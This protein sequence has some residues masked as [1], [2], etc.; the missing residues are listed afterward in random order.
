LEN[1]I[2]TGQ[3][4]VLIGNSSTNHIQSLGGDDL[5]LGNDS[6]DKLDGGEGIDTVSYQRDLGSIDVNLGQ[7]KAK[8][9]FGRND[10][11]LNL[12]NVIGSTFGDR[13]IGNVQA[14]LITAGKG[15]DFVSGESGNDKLFGN[16]GNFD[17]LFG[18]AGNDTITDDDG[19]F[20]AHGGEDN[21]TIDVAFVSDW[22]SPNGQRR[23]DGKITGGYGNDNITV[24][25]NH[26]DF[27]INLKGDEPTSNTPND[28]NDIA[29]LKGTYANSV[30][31]LG[32]GKDTFNGGAGNDNIAAGNGDD[33]LLG[34]SG[35]DK[36]DGQTG[37][38]DQI[39]GGKG[40]DTILDRDGVNGAHGNEGNDKIEIEFAS[41]WDNNDNPNDNPRSDGKITGGF[42]N[43]QITVAMNDNR[44]F[45]N[46]KGDEPTSNQ[47]QDGNDTIT[48]IGSYANSVVDLGGGNDTFNGGSGSD[49]VSG[50]NGNDAIFGF[51]GND[52]LAGD[53]GDDLLRG[54][55][56]KDKLIGGNGS[57][58]FVLAKGEGID[59]IVDFQVELDLIGLA[60][61]LTYGQLSIIQS[62][63]NSLVRNGNETLAILN[64]ITASDLTQGMFVSI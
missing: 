37:F 40:N 26:R 53:N 19:I 62:D 28:G 7:N 34:N 18:G 13:I 23:S 43:D 20:G 44:F 55:T 50:K 29:T 11:L 59:T 45:I 54:G 64:G 21:D 17:K 42:G 38:F 31:D 9:G 32:G 52:Q 3:N 10:E 22:N 41:N 12:E 27:F 56:G 6:D 57:D 4:D 39:F 25:M 46:L 2:A 24:T 36:L 8:E 16:E 60:D 61:G 5:L 1:I 33:R 35:N 58:T 51:N 48:L 15:D 47:S 63:N 49:N 14:N 30:V